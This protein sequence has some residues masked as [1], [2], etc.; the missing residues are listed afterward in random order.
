MHYLLT[1]WELIAMRICMYK[2]TEEAIITT[3]K[4]RIWKHQI[5][6]IMIK[7][8]SADMITWKS[9]RSLT[10]FLLLRKLKRKLLLVWNK[11]KEIKIQM[12]K[13]RMS[14]HFLKKKIK[15]QI[16]KFSRILKLLKRKII[17]M[18]IQI[19]LA[20]MMT[21]LIRSITHFLEKQKS[22]VSEN[23]KLHLLLKQKQN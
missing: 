1:I 13:I 15:E 10:G 23:Q 6:M 2:W 4:K 12:K 17:L 21:K 9:I 19:L 8:L 11:N 20:S 18:K 14:H 7:T 16:Q 22:E 5:T 3:I